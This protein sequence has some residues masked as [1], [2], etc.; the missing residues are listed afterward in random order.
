MINTL[1]NAIM[2]QSAQLTS[3]RG[4][5]AVYRQ[6]VDAIAK[7]VASA[8]V[9]LLTTLPRGGLEVLQPV[10]VADTIVKPYVREWQAEDD[11]SW[12]AI[13]SGKTVR[14]AASSAYVERFLKS[15]GV[16]YVATAPVRDPVFDGYPGAIQ[17]HRTPE[18][19]PFTEADLAKLTAAAAKLGEQLAETRLSRSG[20]EAAERTGTGWAHTPPSRLF[21]LG[22]DGTVLF[23]KQAFN[24]LDDR[25][26]DL[27]LT[28]A[29]QR[30]GKLNGE[31]WA[32]SRLLLPDSAGDHWTLNI[33]VHRRY[34]ALG[35]GPVVFVCLQPTCPEWSTLRSGDFAADPEMSRLIP[36][37]RFMAAEF[38]RGPTLTEIA[39]QVHLSPFHFH[40]RFTELM[41]LT[42]KHF[43]LECQIFD[44]KG[45]LVAGEKELAKIASDCGFAHQSHFTS[46]FKQATGLTP[47]RWRRMAHDRINGVE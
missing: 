43:M 4:D 19:G 41:G 27:V 8:Q 29:Q 22:A 5:G 6:F 7:E 17:A 9:L 24:A 32:S 47:T 23:A 46:R 38:H 36:A 10:K 34:P 20:S 42:P 39:R 13:A 31:P 45:E 21:A 33:I 28:E 26:R 25:L 3:H 12:K 16:Q 15:F 37:L 18:Q 40:R 30:T 11:S 2:S 14:A 44:A 35:E 1:P